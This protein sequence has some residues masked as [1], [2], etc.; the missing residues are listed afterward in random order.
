M[1]EKTKQRLKKAGKVALYSVAAVGAIATIAVVCYQP[2]EGKH[3]PRSLVRSD[4]IPKKAFKSR[5]RANLQSILQLVKH[6]ELCMPYK[7]KDK[8]YTGHNRELNNQIKQGMAKTAEVAANAASA[9]CNTI[10]EPRN[11]QVIA[12]TIMNKDTRTYFEIDEEEY[13][14]M[15]EEEQAQID[16]NQLDVMDDIMFP[17]GHDEDDDYE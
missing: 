6:G 11:V 14:N 15:T 7:V 2:K 8:Y 3:S 9:V 16:E 17:D 10:T 13:D 5:I 12:Q 4:G 1:D